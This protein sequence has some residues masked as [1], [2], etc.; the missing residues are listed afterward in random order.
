MTLLFSF[1]FLL[2]SEAHVQ[3]L[4]ACVSDALRQQESGTS[5]NDR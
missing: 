2:H 4:M 3:T 5:A 1:L